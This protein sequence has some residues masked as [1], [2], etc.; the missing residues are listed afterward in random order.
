MWQGLGYVE[1]SAVPGASLDAGAFDLA[2]HGVLLDP[3]DFGVPQSRPRV[4]FVFRDARRLRSPIDLSTP[5]RTRHVPVRSVID[6]DTSRGFWSNW[7]EH[8]ESTRARIEAEIARSGKTCMVAYHGSEKAGRALDRPCGTLD[9]NDRYRVIVGEVGR[10]LRVEELLAI[11]G[12]PHDY[13][14]AETHKE[15]VCGIGASVVPAVARWLFE[16]VADAI[17]KASR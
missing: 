16:R 10:L 11:G 17:R 4:F 2:N 6:F 9:R 5:P 14:V 3:A 12:F 8:V 7:R 15:A 1:D 13:P